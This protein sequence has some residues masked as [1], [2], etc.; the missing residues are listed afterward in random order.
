MAP[1]T[2]PIY[3]NVPVITS[4]QLTS[5]ITANTNSDGTGTIGTNMV[6]CFTADATNGSFVTKI[7]IWPCANAA[8]TVMTATVIRV[9][10][11]SIASGS[12]TSANTFLYVEIPA[13][14]LTADQTTTAITYYEQTLNFALPPGYTILVSS[15]E[16]QA[17]STLWQCIVW[18]GN[19]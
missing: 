1:N 9:Y 16:G 2:T 13:T 18:G 15:H 17:S 8:A 19:Y 6:L 3:S 11:S 14:A 7:R 12:T 4:G 5:S 10:I